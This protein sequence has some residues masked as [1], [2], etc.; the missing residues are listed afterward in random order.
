MASNNKKKASQSQQ[1][2]TEKKREAQKQAAAKK[3]KQ[4]NITY[5]IIAAI[6]I[7]A[8]VILWFMLPKEGEAP[9]GGKNATIG[10][11]YEEGKEY[12][13]DII[14]KNYGTITVKLD[15]E[16]A[17]IT[18]ENFVNLASS[19]FYDGLTFHR[20]IYGFMMQ[21]GST[22]GLGFEGSPNTIYGEFLENGWDKNDIHHDR[23]V[24]SMARA[25]DPNSANSQFFI[26]HAP[27]ESLDGK[28]AAFGYVTEGM[29]VVDEICST[30][31]PIN[32]NGAIP[33]E[34]QPVIKTIKIYT[35]EE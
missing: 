35:E 27:T 25:K 13:A 24:I 21:G 1:R 10:S 2:G 32:G 17:P 30:V 4:K 26:M 31:Q 12:S 16:A 29:D 7:A 28:Y 5:G 14:I 34:N 6:L 22:D 11:Y 33:A 8:I 15:A 9:A 19:G 23:G 18:V 3:Q 20:I